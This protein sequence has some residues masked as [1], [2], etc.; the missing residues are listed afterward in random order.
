[1]KSQP[2]FWGSIGAVIVLAALCAIPASRYFVLGLLKSEP[3][4]NGLPLSYWLD[5]LTDR[6]GA[7]RAEAART[8][9]SMGPVAKIVVPAL[10]QATRDDAAEVRLAAIKSL[11][12]IGPGAKDAVPDLISF[13]QDQNDSEEIRKAAVVSLGEM[14]S[15]AHDAVPVMVKALAEDES[16]AL[17]GHIQMAMTRMG[18]A[19]VP[20]LIQLLHDENPDVRAHA[21]VAINWIGPSARDAVPALIRSLQDNAKSVRQ[22]AALALL[23]IGPDAKDAVPALAKALQDEAPDVRR[24]AAM[25]LKEVDI[26]AASAE[27]VK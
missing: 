23:R 27:P 5:E 15:A 17:S 14:E 18:P 3:F 12:Q 20:G 10:V 6:N 7:R 13:Y 11:G 8:L 22:G 24:V 4:E 2:A 19:A 26:A 9:G 1:M 16:F 21:A 25:A